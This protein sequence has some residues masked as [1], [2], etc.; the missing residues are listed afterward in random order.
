[1]VIWRGPDGERVPVRMTRTGDDV[2]HGA[3]VPDAVGAW[4]FAIESFSDPYLT[5][6]HA[7]TAKV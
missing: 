7:V 3:I 1:M 4:E 5:W 2:W 6:H